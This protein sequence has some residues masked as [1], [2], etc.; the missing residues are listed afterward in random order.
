MPFTNGSS[1]PTNT[2]FISSAI[3]SVLIASKSFS[4]ILTLVPKATV[5]AFPGAINNFSQS[6]LSAN[7]IANADSLPPEPNNKMFMLYFFVKIEN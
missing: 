7:F 3:Q 5:P 1:G 6:L 4:A 2:K